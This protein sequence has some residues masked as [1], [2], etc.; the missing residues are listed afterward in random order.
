MVSL[1]LQS[2]CQVVL[3]L[4]AYH[5]SFVMVSKF[6]VGLVATTN[7][8]QSTLA[9]CQG[10]DPKA[11]NAALPA[12]SSTT[13]STSGATGTISRDTLYYDVAVIGGGSGGVYTAMGLVDQGK[14]VAVIEKQGRLGGHAHT[15]TDPQTGLPINYGVQVLHNNDLVKEYFARFGL[16][17]TTSPV[18]GSS[19]LTQLAADFNNGKA[20]TNVS[21]SSDPAAI[22]SALATYGS[23]AA[24][25]ASYLA[26]GFNLPDEVPEDLLM[27]FGEFVVKYNISAGLPTIFQIN[28]GIGNILDL[29]TIY[30]FQYLPVDTLI[31]LQNGFIVPADGKMTTLYDAA[32]AELGDDV[33][34]NSNVV[35]VD[36]TSSSN[37]TIT[38]STPTGTKTIIASRLVMAIQP[39][40]DNL[41][42][43]LDLTAEEIDIFSRF[44]HAGYWPMLVNNTGIP[45][46]IQVN[47]YDPNTPFNIPRMPS[48]YVLSPTVIP[49]LKTFYYGSGQTSGPNPSKE[50]VRA[51]MTAGIARLIAGGA[52]GNV[53]SMPN[54]VALEDHG[55]FC[56][57]VSAE[58]IKAGFYK[59]MNTLQGK[60]NTFWTGATWI[61]HD[62]AQIWRFSKGLLPN[63]TAGL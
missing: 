29:P 47:Y 16:N 31:Y 53:T 36:R 60:G 8:F 56:L 28:Q 3:F 6:L 34:L 27:P 24:S 42:S 57:Q 1:L 30:T 18:G 55:A 21:I 38:L 50:E 12:D 23:I 19:S 46:N 25:Y 22:G 11:N 39:T 10:R 17:T 37:V 9:A 59:K 20:L 41:S 43:F 15:Y 54:V 52:V 2:A 45:D 14:T 48:G 4:S 7:I 61:A 13:Q 26:D 33:F 51:Q 63:I 44:T 49:G 40:I 32:A 62:S 35:S 5:R 58:E